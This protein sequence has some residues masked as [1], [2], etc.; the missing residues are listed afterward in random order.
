M[1]RA[2][3]V[4]SFLI[5]SCIILTFQ[6]HVP[7]AIHPSLDTLDPSHHYNY[8]SPCQR[9][10]P[11]VGIIILFQLLTVIFVA[12]GQVELILSQG[13]SALSH[14]DF[15]QAIEAYRKG[16]AIVDQVGDV[17]LST[18]ISL[19]TNLGTALSSAGLNNEAAKEY[20]NAL[21]A[22]EENILEI[23]DKKVKNEV[24][25]I[26][27]QAAF[28]LGQVYQDLEQ[29]RDAVEAYTFAHSIDPQNWSAAANLG[30]VLQDSIGNHEAALQAY[31][32]AYNILNGDD[33]PTDAP[34]EP[35]YIL[36]QLQYRIGLCITHDVNRKCARVD[37]PDRQVD[38]NELAAHAF[39]LAVEYD[40]MNE[41]AKHMLATVTADGSLKAAS[42]SYI[43]TLFDDYAANFEH[44]LVQEL[45]YTGYQRLR[46]AFD[47]ALGLTEKTTNFAKVVDAGCG[48][49]LAG[50]QFRNISGTL[51][52]VDLSEAI[53]REA[54]VARPDL[55]DETEANDVTKVF[56]AR[57]PISL[58]IAADSYIYF[59]DLDPLF[60]SMTEG[61]EEDG[62]AAFTLEDVD[63]ET[64]NVLEDTKPEW[65]WQLTKSG[66]FAHRRG[67][68]EET[69]RKYGLTP[70]HYEALVDFRYEHGKGV[71]GHIFV[72]RKTTS[73]GSEL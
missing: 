61:L 43:K 12:A 6:S 31:N 71:Q 4:G 41:A 42:T 73:R 37:A 45:G 66:R 68:V 21:K 47:R 60:E 52:G 10:E 29:P 63:A 64:A 72:M 38:C 30:A 56:K 55:Y 27:A 50:E 58:I 69:A 57:K 49:G 26:T 1:R 5:L 14:G 11:M 33:E 2:R 3:T 25:L 7:G 24:Q 28:F 17:S 22:Y 15:D 18:E 34:Q 16:I 65:R 70:I 59:G 54:K 8:I 23:V 36:G 53:I 20:Q 13:D 48:T 40:D 67:Y 44:S 39:S 32:T 51:I 9:S 46:I 19:Y 35:R 62:Y